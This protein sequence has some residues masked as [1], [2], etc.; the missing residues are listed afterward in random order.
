MDDN[1]QGLF[2]LAEEMGYSELQ[3]GYLSKC[4]LCMD[5]RKFIMHRKDFKELRPK[6]FYLHLE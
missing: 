5:I 6:E 4:H 3:D 2:S 1:L